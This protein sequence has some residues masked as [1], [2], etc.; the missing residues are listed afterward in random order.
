M[1]I[2]LLARRQMA[3]HEPLRS[4]TPAVEHGPSNPE[5]PITDESTS[6][7]LIDLLVLDS[8]DAASTPS[9]GGRTGENEGA[10]EL[11]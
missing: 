11:C 1:R 5:E 6:T 10:G 2:A 7:V 9:S 4:P 8:D 3:P